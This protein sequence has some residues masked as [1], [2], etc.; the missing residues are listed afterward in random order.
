MT[1]SGVNT[2]IYHGRKFADNYEFMTNTSL[3]VLKRHG[4]LLVSRDRFEKALCNIAK[5]KFEKD[6]GNI[7]SNEEVSNRE[8][9]LLGMCVKELLAECGRL[10]GY[11][12]TYRFCAPTDLRETATVIFERVSGDTDGD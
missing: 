8:Q 6:L 5:T 4:N 3:D 2:D 7:F 9:V 12:L 11:K 10:S 1:Y